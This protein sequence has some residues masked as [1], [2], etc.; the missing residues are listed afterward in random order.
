[1]TNGV[2]KDKNI[3]LSIIFKNDQFK[4]LKL[5]NVMSYC[6]AFVLFFKGIEKKINVPP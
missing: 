5:F 2:N 4:S 6:S 3:H 1:M